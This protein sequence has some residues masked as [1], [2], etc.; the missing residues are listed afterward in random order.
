MAPQMIQRT[1]L[2]T[3]TKRAIRTY[4]NTM[5]LAHDNK[6]PREEQLCEIIGV[7]RVTLRSA[8]NEL[9]SEGVILRRQGKGTF[10]N[11]TGLGIKA[12][13][14]P[15]MHFGDVIANSG[16]TPHVRLLGW[17]HEP[18]DESVA[19]AFDI[20]AG[21]PC[22]CMRKMFYA[23]QRP[24]VYCEDLFPAALWGETPL[25]DDTTA[26]VFQLLYDRT[27][28]QVAWDKVELDVCTSES[29]PDL[30]QFGKRPLLL[31][32]SL[33]YDSDDQPLFS[34]WEYIDTELLTLSQIRRREFPYTL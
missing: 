17:Q 3:Q 13:F 16:Y 27:G 5:D 4:I 7:S 22:I 12:T 20:P 30:Y 33:T 19:E 6:L 31:L 8:L 18:A 14:N 26:S 28:R 21:T 15:A 9:E 25:P 24:C 34:A 29:K 32:K 11:R 2:K 23:D 1:D 10:V